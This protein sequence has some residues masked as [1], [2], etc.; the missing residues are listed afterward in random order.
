MG[1]TQDPTEFIIDMQQKWQTETGEPWDNS[2]GTTLMFTMIHQEGLPKPVQSRLD[3][4]VSLDCK[5]WAKIQA[6]I[7][8]FV[9]KHREKEKE[10]RG[11]EENLKNTLIKKQL[12]ALHSQ[13]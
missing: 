5:P 12:A 10:K 6:H 11:G 8:H 4:A 2:K 13:K 1:L 3:E 9:R 7:V